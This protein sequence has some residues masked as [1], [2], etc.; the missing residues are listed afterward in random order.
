[1][2]NNTAVV[3]RSPARS[4]IAM[5]RTAEPKQPLFIAAAVIVVW[6]V[7]ILAL[8][9]NQWRLPEVPRAATA[10]GFSAER[11]AAHLAVITGQPHP[12]GSAESATV[13]DYIMSELARLGLQPE[14]HSSQVV[15]GPQIINVHN[16][17]ALIPGSE[18]SSYIL[19]AAH[20]DS[21]PNSPGAADDGSGVVTLLET[22]RAIH[23]SSGLRHPVMLLFTDSEERGLGGARAFVAG[24]AAKKIGV[25]INL[26]ARGNSGPAFMF[27]TQGGPGALVRQFGEAAPVPVAN[28]LMPE[29]Y[30]RLDNETD[31]TVF[32]QAGLSG[33]N[34]AFIN[35][36]ISYH[37]A[38]DSSSAFDGRSLQHMGDTV[39]ALVWKFGNESLPV[40]R[41]N[42][43]Y[44]N[45][46]RG[47]LAVYPASW[48]IPLA[49]LAA[50]LLATAVW[51]G[52][53]R[54]KLTA[55]RIVVGFASS[56]LA[57]IIA[58]GLAW[59][60][61]RAVLITHKQFTLLPNSD[62]YQSSTYHLAIG[63]LAVSAITAF[64]AWLLKRNSVENLWTGTLIWFAILSVATSILVPGASYLFSW[65]LLFLAAGFL[66]VVRKDQ[67]SSSLSSALVLAACAVPGILLLA[68]AVRMLFWVF[69]MSLVAVPVILLSLLMA[70]LLPQ[71]ELLFLLQRLLPAGIAAAVC[72]IAL[73]VGGKSAVSSPGTP[74]PSNLLYVEQADSRSAY[75]V[76]RTTPDNWNSTMIGRSAQR[77][78]CATLV[79]TMAGP[80]WIG[81]AAYTEA[82]PPVV[83][84]VSD[85][86]G[87]NTRT[88]RLKISSPRHASLVVVALDAGAK[89]LA[90]SVNGHDLGVASGSVPPS[91]LRLAF[92]APRDQG[93][94]LVCTVQGKGVLPVTAIDQSYGLQ[95][96]PGFTPRPG[97]YIP[98]GRESDSFFLT[99]SFKF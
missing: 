66:I 52:L 17:E 96:L 47:I 88:V 24:A 94:E 49:L 80:C 32:R 41:Q 86:H 55:A 22:A 71:L 8:A 19:L 70:F 63:A 76:S 87:D 36:L 65:P 77:Q 39:T 79:L 13:R 18:D 73:I 53:Q 83:E 40:R 51:M 97:S 62:S 60:A 45:V 31:F 82:T 81:P 59:L 72:V 48:S 27:E 34:F 35:H 67:G 43:V 9:V 25:V 37:T 11:A 90:A 10:T 46:L 44:F 57:F 2:L 54:R 75:W 15:A 5:A 1:M 89:L 69:P 56:A 95:G 74:L 50:I 20:Y 12:V 85:Q 92:I 58:A 91:G 84:M 7:G 28:S 38:V 16:I 26:D 4:S 6:L 42:V 29:L 64:Y 33:F 61:W 93:E 78:P 23:S 30:R 99:R 3:T 98:G 68:P 21:V 14:I